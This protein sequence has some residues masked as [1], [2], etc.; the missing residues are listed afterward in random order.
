MSSA[1]L[2]DKISWQ[3]PATRFL[4]GNQ[5][6]SRQCLHIFH[7]YEEDHLYFRRKPGSDLAAGI[8]WETMALGQNDKINYNYEFQTISHSV[9][10][11]HEDEEDTY[12][13]I[14][15]EK[16]TILKMVLKVI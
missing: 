5:N 13:E 9:K 12:E 15:D 6:S 7:T 3:C 16:F 8:C 10:I 14:I 1:L 11:E 4:R 2:L